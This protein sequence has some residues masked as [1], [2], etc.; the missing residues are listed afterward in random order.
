MKNS[1]YFIMIINKTKQKM[2]DGNIEQ[3]EIKTE[4]TDTS[5]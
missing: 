3:G 5:T 4:V 1:A 2:I